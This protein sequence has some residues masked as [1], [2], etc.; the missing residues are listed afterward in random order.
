MFGDVKQ[1]KQSGNAND[2]EQAFSEEIKQVP[3]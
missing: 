2:F 1:V 3:L